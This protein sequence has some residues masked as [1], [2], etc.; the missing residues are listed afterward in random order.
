MI[1][2]RRASRSTSARRDDA[3]RDAAAADAR[4]QLRDD[5]RAPRRRVRVERATTSRPRACAPAL[6]RAARGRGRRAPASARCAC[7]AAPAMTA[8]AMAALCPIGMLFVR[9]KGGISHNPA[10]SITAEDADTARCR[11]R[12][13]PAPTSARAWRP[14]DARQPSPT[15]PPLPR[16]RPRAR[17]AAFLAELVKVPSDNPPGDCAAARRRARRSCSRA[18]PHGRARIPCRRR[19]CAPTAWSAPP[20][21]SSAAASARA[22]RRSRSTRMATSCRPARA[23]RRTPMAP[24]SWTAGCTAAAS[25][26]R[27]PTSPPT[28]SPLLALEA[29][30]RRAARTARSSCTSPTTRRRAARSARSWLLEQGLSRPDLAI[31]AGFSYAVVTAHNGCLHLEVEVDGRSAHAAMPFTGVDALEAATAIL[32]RPLR[33]GARASRERRLGRSPG[34]GSPAAHG[35]ADQGR[36]QHQRRARPGDLPPRPPHHPGGEP[37]RGRGASCAPSSPGAAGAS[38]RRQGRGPPHPAG[39]A[40]D[41]LCPA[42]SG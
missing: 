24:R 22:A 16:R 11:P 26:S 14:T 27:S 41:A 21:S 37:G 5:R 40:A 15:H 8:L 28:P 42:A 36:H 9:C 6:H 23:G 1:P 2:A 33:A 19:W 10:E 39:R 12:R 38:R 31:G 4:A 32:A 25:P 20:T 18:G 35:R 17:R 34:I 29:A 7:R 3:V 30:R 13:L